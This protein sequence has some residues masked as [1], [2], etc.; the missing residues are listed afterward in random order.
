[1]KLLYLVT[2]KKNMKT[3]FLIILLFLTLDPVISQTILTLRECYENAYSLAPLSVEKAVYSDIWQL[4]D[5]NLSKKW[6]PVLD[7][8]AAFLYNSS[9]VDMTDIL[10]SLPVPGINDFIKPLPHEQYKL[11]LD[12]NQTIYDGGAVKNARSLEKTESDIHVKQTEAELYKVREII[13]NCYFNLLLLNRQKELLQNYLD[14]I[15]KRISSVNSAFEGGVRLKSDADVLVSER[16]KLEQ[17]VSEVESKKIALRKILSDLTEIKID[18]STVLVMPSSDTV[19]STELLRP[20]LQ[21]FD[22]R[23]EQ[24]EKSRQVVNSK[25]MPKAFV[26]ASLGYGNPP[27]SNFFKDEFAPYYVFGAGVKWN[28]F[29]WNLIKNEKQL[30]NLH[31]EI[32]GCR[33]KDVQNNLIRLLDMKRAE[34]TNLTA[35]IKTDEELIEIRK[36]ITLAAESKYENGT[37]TATEYM[38][39]LVA[40]RQ[41][42]I[43]YEIHKISLAM[44]VEEYLNIRGNETD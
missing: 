3:G 27:G 43:N 30:I 38:N 23:L 29:D 14:L 4:K 15:N 24:L 37:I 6:L 20:E 34:I 7:A 19:L 36:R 13:S 35:L 32:V 22:L 33:K 25:R 11:T 42:L 40:E 21:V 17:Q 12:I 39:E 41:A 26:F 31:Q 8:N 18:D 16:I 9:V 28:I 1:M 5:K 2:L 44:T 10:G